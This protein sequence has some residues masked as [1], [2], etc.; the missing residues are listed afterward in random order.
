MIYVEGCS[1]GFG[2]RWKLEV[3]DFFLKVSL[4]I[5]IDSMEV[6][7][8]VA[9]IFVLSVL[10]KS[11]VLEFRSTEKRFCDAKI[12]EGCSDDLFLLSG[13]LGVNLS[14]RSH[15]RCSFNQAITF[16]CQRKN[17]F[18][19]FDSACLVVESY[20]YEYGSGRRYWY[21]NRCGVR[22]R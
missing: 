6:Q 9:F 13:V 7:L 17:F 18:F 8:F 19:L 21:L 2:L 1:Q 11:K 22:E 5:S 3:F 14:E 4:A 12:F 15:F 10:S 16:Y 20:K